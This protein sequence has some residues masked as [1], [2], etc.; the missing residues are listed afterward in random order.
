M[1]TRAQLKSNAKDV[2]KRCYWMSF[3]AALVLTLATEGKLFDFSYRFDRRD[4][5][6]F[7]HGDFSF[8]GAFTPEFGEQLFRR[9]SP[10]LP[11]IIGASTVVFLLGLAISYLVMAPLE[12]G[13]TR[14]F[15]EATQYRFRLEELTYG[16]AG[17][18]YFNVVSAMLL[19]SVYNFLWF[20]L[21]VIPGI[22]KG[23]AYSLVP[24]LLAEN[25]HLPPARAVA[26]STAMTRGY[27]WEMFVLDVS[28]AGWYILGALALGV[29]V[30]FVRPY[31][32]A[33]KA[34]LYLA[35]RASALER[36]VVAPFELEGN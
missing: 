7:F 36:S 18:G 3:L 20:L 2:L 31:H 33:T 9:I 29:G 21:L 6:R 32:Y 17:G 15:L 4:L 25:P 26:L 30:L 5:P 28:F 14:F 1:W 27:K 23:Y 19:R 22:V 8:D 16:F 35:L 12:V 10:F 34:Q 13:A 24:Y 11:L